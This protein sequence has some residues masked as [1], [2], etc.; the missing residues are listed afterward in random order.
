MMKGLETDQIQV[1]S[2]ALG[3]A[4]TALEDAP[5]YAQEHESF[6]HPITGGAGYENGAHVSLRDCAESLCAGLVGQIRTVG[7]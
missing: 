4:A 2:R 1:A 6:G 7:R 3:V 5:R